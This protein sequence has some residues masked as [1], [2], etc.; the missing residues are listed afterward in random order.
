[1]PHGYSDSEW[2]RMNVRTVGEITREKVRE[3]QGAPPEVPEVLSSPHDE[4]L[5]APETSDIKGEKDP[6]VKE[7]KVEEVPPEPKKRGR[8]LKIKVVE[9]KKEKKTK[10]AFATKR[11]RK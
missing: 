11:G 7:E 8:S 1:M 9:I 4:T 5:V 2:A 10:V 3:L 6:E